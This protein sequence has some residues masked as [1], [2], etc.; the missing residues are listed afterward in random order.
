MTLPRGGWDHDGADVA[1]GV[2]ISIHPPRGGWD[3]LFLHLRICRFDFNPPTPWGVGHDSIYRAAGL[4]PFQSTHPVGGGTVGLAVFGVS[5][6]ISIH[7][8]RGGW[9]LD[10]RR[11]AGLTTPFQST[12]PVGG[13]TGVHPAGGQ[14]EKISIHPPRGGWDS[15]V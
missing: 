3:P 10:K 6:D 14:T 15:N 12:H 7:P 5:L 1:C 4:S 11:M 2:G 9:D 13:G 8:P